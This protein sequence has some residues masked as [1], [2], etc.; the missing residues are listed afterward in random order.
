[1]VAAA[2]RVEVPPASEQPA[3]WR[4][5]LLAA[6]VLAAALVVL[7][8]LV[9]AGALVPRIDRAILEAARPHQ[10]WGA[11]QRFCAHVAAD[12]RPPHVLIAFAVV[13]AAI[14]LQRRSVFPVLFAAA[15][16]AALAA[17]TLGLKSAVAARDP[18]HNLVSGGSFPSG[19]TA[20]LL[21]AFGVI[22]LLY[23]G[24]AAALLWTLAGVATTALGAALIVA[25]VHW[26]SDV[27]G[28]AL[29]AGIILLLAY[30]SCIHPGPMRSLFAER[31]REK[32]G[33]IE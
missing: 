31:T 16:E 23:R 4:R 6:A 18:Q 7:A 3:N 8:A 22:A 32:R 1:M 25:G 14:A 5:P 10:R 19:H 21:L 11:V 28:G 29:L 33:P 17:G 26:T 20:Q 2:E 9:A 30:A 27:I 15:C 24:R 13:I 12:A